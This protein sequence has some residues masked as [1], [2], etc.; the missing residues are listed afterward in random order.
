MSAAVDPLLI[1]L[2]VLCGLVSCSDSP[3]A[4]PVEPDAAT[5]E[6]AAEAL[7]E[8][9]APPSADEPTAD[10]APAT[11]GGDVTPG[12]PALVD[13]VQ[14]EL[15]WSGVGNLHKSFFADTAVIQQLSADLTGEVRS[16]APIA[17]RY[18]SQAFTGQIHLLLDPGALPRP[19]GAQGDVI[20]LQDLAP[21]TTALARYR[22]AVA[23]RFDL[24]VESFSVA[25]ESVRS[26]R[27]C[28]F[29]VAGPP[30]P[31]GRLVSPCV[32]INGA[33]RCGEPTPEGVRFA[34]DAAADV[35]ACLD[36]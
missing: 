24:R 5:A 2:L 32:H 18:D 35:R 19:V 23:A 34:A 36:Q 12:E 9:Q 1:R 28:T 11:G 7:L 30:P 20:R 26:G 13:P 4:Q 6:A 17:V 10:A 3:P 31:D 27:A 25:I 16:P 14:P 29:R 22:S 21:L 33:D 15:Q 8:A